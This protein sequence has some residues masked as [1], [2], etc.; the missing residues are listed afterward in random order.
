MEEYRKGKGRERIGMEECRKG[1]GRKGL[2]WKSVGRVREG[3]DWYARVKECRLKKGEER[4]DLSFLRSSH[5][6]SV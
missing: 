1:K 5:R 3:K 6:I 2:V 4:P